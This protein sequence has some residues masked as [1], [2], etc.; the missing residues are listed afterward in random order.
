MYVDH[1]PPLGPPAPAVGPLGAGWPWRSLGLRRS[2]ARCAEPGPWIVRGAA[3][4]AIDPSQRLHS[5]S[6]HVLIWHDPLPANP[7]H[8]VGSVSLPPF[9]QG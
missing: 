5:P 3:H 6:S 9:R 7:L 1:L 2:K 8:A 4:A